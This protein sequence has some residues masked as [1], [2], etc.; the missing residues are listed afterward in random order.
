MMSSE[1]TKQSSSRSEYRPK[2]SGSSPSR[3]TLED[4]NSAEAPRVWLLHQLKLK[5]RYSSISF[6]LISKGPFYISS[7]TFITIC[8]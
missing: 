2:N 5:E 8:K 6:I 3:A 7:D 4:N 1:L